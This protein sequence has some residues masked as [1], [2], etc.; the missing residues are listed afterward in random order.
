MKLIS[1]TVEYREKN[2]VTRNDFLD[3]LIQLKNKGS[4]RE[5]GNAEDEEGFGGYKSTKRS[6]L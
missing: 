4:L 1:D 3:L 2:G 6:T 5:E